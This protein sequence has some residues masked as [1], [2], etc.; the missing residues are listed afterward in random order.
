MIKNMFFKQK[1]IFNRIYNKFSSSIKV[2]VET[3]SNK[4]LK[5]D[6]HKFSIYQNVIP[7]FGKAPEQQSFPKHMTD[8]IPPEQF[9]VKYHPSEP[10]NALYMVI[11]HNY[12]YK[13]ESV[14]CFYTI[15]V[16]NMNYHV[17]NA[18]RVVSDFNLAI[19]KN[20]ELCG[21]LYDGEKSSLY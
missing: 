1:M 15:R 5:N 11:N 4:T 3:N 21:I 12:P 18:A 9:G 6:P 7:K 13:K 20:F 2:D 16:N 8:I 17:F 10:L 19:R 14:S